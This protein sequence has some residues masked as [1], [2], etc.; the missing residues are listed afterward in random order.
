M[1]I[2]VT[3]FISPFSERLC[4]GRGGRNMSLRYILGK[5][6]TGKTTRCINEIIDTDN[7]SERIFYIVPEQFTLE[8]EKNLLDKKDSVS[9]I[10][11][12]GFRHF[13]YYLISKMGT[14]GRV[15]LDD[16]GRAMLI[17][18]I[19]L[20]LK[21]KLGFYKNSADKQ[22]FIDNLDETIAE[23]MQYSV[24]SEK[25]AELVL[26]LNEGNLKEKLKDIQLIF[27]KYR[28]YL[29]EKYIADDGILEILAE[30]I[31][32]S[33]VKGSEVWIDGFKSFTPQENK[34]IAVLL[35]HCKRVNIALNLNSPSIE[36][37][38]MST[39]DEQYEVKRT[40]TRITSIAKENKINIEEVVFLKK[41]Y[42]KYNK[43][44]E[45]LKDNYFKYKF[46][47]YEKEVNNIVIYK[48]NN[49]YQEIEKVCG[50]I[51]KLVQYKNYRYK[52]IALI[53]GDSS[54]E[55][56]LSIALKK[57]DIPNFLDG[58]KNVY[59][60]PVI[61]FITA[62]V[63]IIAYGWDN[64]A[65]F[66]LLKTGYTDISFDEIFMLENYTAAN[67]INRYKWNKEWKY[68]FR[69]DRHSDRPEKEVIEGIRDRVFEILAPL[70]SKYNS[71]KKAVIS[72]ITESLFQVLDNV[73]I[74]EK[75][76]DELN[77]AKYRGDVVRSAVNEEI[78]NIVIDVVD[79]M[80]DILGSEK[81]SFKEYSKILKIGLNTA[82]IGIAPPTQ[83]Y[84][85]VGDMER[86][87]L[88]DIK[89]MFV[90]GA[91]EGNIPVKMVEKGI[92][93][94]EEK[95]TME[96]NDIELAP[97]IIQKSN[98]GKLGIYLN[99]IKATEY[100]TISYPSGSISGKAM[101]R[102]SII[103]KITDIFPKLRERGI[104]DNSFETEE[105]LT[106]REAAFNK[107]VTAVSNDNT[108]DFIKELYLY[109]SNDEEYSKRLR[110][111]KYG[112]FSSIPQ[113]Y[114]DERLLTV[115]WEEFLCSGSVSKLETFTS[116][117][118]RFYMNY[119]LKAKEKEVYKL[120]YND[121]GT[122]T[123][124]IMEEFSRHIKSTG[125][126][127]NKADREYTDSFIDRHIYDIVDKTGSDIFESK[128]NSAILNKIINSAKLSLWANVEQIKAS[129]FKPENFEISFGKS[130]SKIPAI[131]IEVEDNKIL[132]L[133]GVIDRVDKM[134]LEDG[135]VYVKIV[136]YKSSTKS[137]DINKI[138]NG[139]QLQLV[140]YMNTLTE[141][142]NAEP[143]GMFYFKVNEPDLINEEQYKSELSEEDF[144]LNRMALNGMYDENMA[145]ELDLAKIEVLKNRK[146]VEILRD[147]SGDKSSTLDREQ[148]HNLLKY[149]REVVRSIGKEMA[150]G[151]IEIS[152]YK[153]D[154]ECPCNYCPYGIVCNFENSNGEKLRNIEKADNEVWSKIN[155]D[156][157]EIK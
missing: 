91:N 130:N 51:K 77:K 139:L 97:N 25:M 95:Q 126:E 66:K 124:K 8:S 105:V 98:N 69:D 116:C 38:G 92:F 58:R 117:P 138:Y 41:D 146:P 13:A 11:V 14:S 34:V 133:N 89:A 109:F 152:P 111:I 47:P 45:Y 3:V 119:I 125:M 52:D 36:Y 136:D 101:T 87:R 149:S 12:L 64:G 59:S 44:I 61:T 26:K 24:A 83:D 48:A 70:N 62:A 104:D 31:P 147:I 50:E 99:I 110:A 20:E 74:T 35:K 6:G 115:L 129:K 155:K 120:K 144:I 88:P 134:L 123:H 94:D 33:V 67:G 28:K 156:E 39:F 32:H 49:M 56:P 85:I 60:H 40:V 22:G 63:D 37:K 23:L 79:K 118:F 157:V 2:P 154:N 65:V 148:M 29:D 46:K 86:T 93:T 140:L 112:I 135:S 4:G 127:W 7:M 80:I 153:Y 90:L 107:L 121:I 16:V 30:L 103:N 75:L 84:L 114:L 122:L 5:S 18:K 9:N 21:D 54:Y 81:V 78:W 131:E 53:I 113:D 106:G 55:V 100:L 68:G 73:N 137:L 1:L 76:E 27:E 132:R 17:K 10:N 143:G 141:K 19:V 15:M 72:E 150:K 57:Y 151:N 128:R 108:S 43:E 142:G 145:E 71:S 96:D 82:T 102:S 42:R